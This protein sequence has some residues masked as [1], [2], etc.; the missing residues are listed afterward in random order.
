MSK[1]HKSA[2]LSPAVRQEAAKAAEVAAAA[3][4]DATPAAAS[5]AALSAAAEVLSTAQ[6]EADAAAEAAKDAKRAERKAKGKGKAR[7][8]TRPERADFVDRKGNKMRIYVAPRSNGTWKAYAVLAMVGQ[9][10]RRGLELKEV[11]E[12]TARDRFAQL[13]ETAV[14]AGWTLAAERSGSQAAEAFTEMPAAVNE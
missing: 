6:E 9:K 1:H 8:R 11:P 10:K 12:A 7:S 13:K 2:P 5:N 3:V 4:T 14:K